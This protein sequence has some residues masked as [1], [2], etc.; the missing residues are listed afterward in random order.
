MTEPAASVVIATRDRPAD[1][2]RCLDALGRQAD[3]P[4][5]EVVVVD[6]GSIPPLRAAD[7][8]SGTRL[9]RGDGRGPGA[10]RNAGVA[11]ARAATILFTDDDTIPGPAWVRAACAA[12]AAHPDAV[13]VEGTTV[14]AP[15]DPLYARSVAGAGGAYLTCNIAY[16]RSVLD[17][18]GGFADVFPHPHAED[19]DLAYRA[20][21]R[22]PIAHEPAMRVEHPVT[23]AS[24]GSLVRR[25]RFLGSEVTLRSRH[26]DRFGHVVERGPLWLQVV[27]GAARGQVR[28]ARPDGLA[29]RPVR[30]ARLLALVVGQSLVG[31]RAA[32][33]QPRAARWTPDA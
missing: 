5:F 6:D 19:L 17:A 2:R 4:P 11:A 7:L 22:G 12:L 3:A 14:T 24:L 10:A 20:L 8:P 29:R 23:P 13:A 9:L 27:Q 33:R 28:A 25:G 26:P 16:R 30:A 32:A 15:Y 21:S 1:L 18:V 31:A